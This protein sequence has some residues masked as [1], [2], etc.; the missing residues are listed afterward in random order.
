MAA[1]R[2]G[3]CINLSQ[4]PPLQLPPVPP[5]RHNVCRDRA[6]TNGATESV[7]QREETPGGPRQQ[8]G[9][10]AP[11]WPCVEEVLERA[12]VEDAKLLPTGSNYVFVLALRDD[13]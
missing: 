7:Q 9:N 3:N 4:R 6:A 1:P 11:E 5:P 13:E 10:W 12:G 2:A 8:N